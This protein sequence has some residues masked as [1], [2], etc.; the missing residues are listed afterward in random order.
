MK[1]LLLIALFLLNFSF[2]NAQVNAITETGEEVTLFNNGTWK[3]INKQESGTAVIK[4]NPQKFSTPKT[5]SFLLKSKVL[6]VGFYLDPKKWSF[7]KA[8]SNPDAEY[9]LKMRDG[10]LYAVVITERMNMPLSSLREVAITN[11]KSVSADVTVKKEEYR[12]VNGKKILLLV[13]YG[14]MQGMDFYY[15]SYYFSNENGIVQFITYSGQNLFDEYETFSEEL[16]N[17]LV[18]IKE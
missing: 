13:M 15:Y 18:E 1:N 16:L 10:D 7:T 9:E 4:T 5:S 11:A 8:E 17:G 12:I 6:N 3:F 2:T 14:S